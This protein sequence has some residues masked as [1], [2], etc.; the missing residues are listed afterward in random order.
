MIAYLACDL[1]RCGS[2]TVRPRD[3]GV[4]EI[5]FPTPDL[6]PVVEHRVIVTTEQLAYLARLA[7]EG[8]GG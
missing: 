8:H 3:P 4:W 2:P 5:V 7:T 1:L 6:D